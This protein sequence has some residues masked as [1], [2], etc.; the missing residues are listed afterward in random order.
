MASR[1]QLRG[2]DHLGR[3]DGRLHRASHRAWDAACA[4]DGRGAALGR[5]GSA[6]G[7]NRTRLSCE[8]RYLGEGGDEPGSPGPDHRC[9]MCRRGWRARSRPGAGS[10]AGTPSRRR[11]ERGPGRPGP[12]GAQVSIRRAAPL[13]Q[14]W[15]HP[16]QTAASSQF[17][18]P[19]CAPVEGLSSGV[20]PAESSGSC[21]GRKAWFSAHFLLRGGANP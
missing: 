13:A 2:N 5:G 16:P 1:Q 19:W 12:A 18:R 6:M 10:R 11:S 4:P 21:Q 15:R 14:P 20:G 17:R 8:R 9:L 7:C 3:N